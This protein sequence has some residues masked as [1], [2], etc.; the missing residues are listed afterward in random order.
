MMIAQITDLHVTHAGGTLFG[1]YDPAATL[2]ATLAHLAELDPRPDIVLITGD[3]TDS[4][5]P[6]EY[7]EFRRVMSGFGLPAAAIPGNH[8]RRSA[9]VAALAGSCT[10]IG[11]LPFLNL[12]ID[13]GELRLLGLD[14]LGDEG[15]AAGEICDRRLDWLAAE[16]DAEPGRP[17]LIFMHHPPFETGISFMDAIG[18]VGGARLADPVASHG[19]V[20]GIICGHVHR[21]ISVAFGG[22]IAST[23][24]SV[25]WK[26]PLELGPPG[27]PRMLQERPAFQLHLWTPGFGLISHT[28]F[29]PCL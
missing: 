3:I 5:A 1:G 28:E 19:A 12:A 7:A 11:T 18:C 25:A 24:P 4:G 21:G 26:V 27:P 9:L 16:L 13:L 8:D 17:T 23:C 6:D 22:T 20:V 10:R 14:T 2:A 29:L 15:A